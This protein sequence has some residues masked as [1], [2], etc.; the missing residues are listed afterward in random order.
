MATIEIDDVQ[1]AYGDVTALDGLSMRF[2]PGFNVV[3]GP[4]GSGKTTLFRVGAGNEEGHAYECSVGIASQ[5]SKSR[6]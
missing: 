4:N 3:L 6:S 5:L 2:D 1:L